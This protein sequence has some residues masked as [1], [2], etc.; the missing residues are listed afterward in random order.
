MPALVMVSDGRE[1]RLDLAGRT[2]VVGRSAECDVQITENRASRRHFQ[3][4]PTDRGWVVQDLD[5]SNGTAVNGYGISRV[6]LSNG[7]LI[8][9]GGAAFRYE[10]DGGAPA[11]RTPKPPR[12]GASTGPA[13]VGALVVAVAAAVISDNLAADTAGSRGREVADAAAK[14]AHTEYL[15][16]CREPDLEKMEAALAEHLRAH[17]GSADAAQVRARITAI[18]GAR[19]VRKAASAD[20]DALQAAAATISPEEYRWQLE[21]LVRR[22]I[23]SPEGVGEIRRRAEA[24]KPPEPPAEDARL[25]FQRRKR[26]ADAALA[27]GKPGRALSIWNAHA[28]ESP[29]AAPGADADLR[30]E[31]RSVE[32]AAAGKAEE[33][34]ERAAK[35]RDQGKADEAAKLC[36]DA[37]ADLGGTGGG[38]RVAARIDSGFGSI[39]PPR[40]TASATP[41]E[42]EGFARKRDFVLRARDAEQFVA[43]RD[44]AGAA[45]LYAGIVADAKGLDDLRAEFE[46]R[47]GWL[48]RVADALDALRAL[49]GGRGGK[50]WPQAWDEVPAEELGAALARSVRKPEDRIPVI[51]FAYDQG[52]K[53]LALDSVCAALDFEGTHAEAERLYS[54]REGLAIPEGGFV[55]D[56]GEVVSRG[57][58]KRRR[59]AEAIGKHREREAAILRRLHDNVLVRSIDRMRAQRAE[60][61][62]ARAF[63]LELIFDEIKYFYPYQD[64]RGEYDKVQ[65][66]VDRRVKAVQDLWDDRAKL[67]TKPDSGLAAALKEFDAEAAQLKELGAE[68]AAPEKEVANLRLYLNRELDVRSFFVDADDLARH[69][70]D[71]G[72]LKENEKR[73]AVADDSE[74]RQVEVTNEYRAMFG[75]RALLVG[76]K[77]V[78]S[79]RA[80]GDDMSKG[81]FFDHFNVRLQNMKPGE[82]VPKQACGCSSDGFVPGCSHGPDA[83]IRAQGYEFSACSENIHA[84]SGDPEGAHK[85]W[86]HSSGHHRNILTPEWKEMGTGRVGKFWT[87]NFGLPLSPVESGSD[88]AG[89]TPW[90]RAGGRGTGEDGNPPEGK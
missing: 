14:V 62:K 10:T 20:F 28:L 80:H 33:V 89:S 76:D 38:R 27:E 56:K 36:R 85:G 64:R 22:W 44:Y 39:A 29:P 16:A 83:R 88:G 82:K 24:A 37:L 9:V 57:E 70:Y 67:R 58:W 30:S 59:N 87:Q 8:E 32:F 2:F 52:L 46:A 90:D 40:G 53:K 45:G 78:L 75:R 72:V 51:A 61:D 25:L 65:Q 7:D 35:L 15:I 12:K 69:E 11:P 4:E 60:L 55:A 84:G 86:I 34:L 47:A 18:R 74:R 79:A 63:A 73:K 26:E 5:S 41:A 66:E 54:L 50:P 19:E 42:A 77:L 1:T 21:R 68:P 48:R 3:V 13:W 17:P 23:D 81:G 31:V 49:P 71:A 43:L 6:L